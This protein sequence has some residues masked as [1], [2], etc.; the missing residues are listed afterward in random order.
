[1]VNDYHKLC[2]V[3]QIS[4]TFPVECMKTGNEKKWID[5]LPL[6]F[7]CYRDFPNYCLNLKRKRKSKVIDCFA[8]SCAVVAS[9]F[10]CLSAF[11]Y[12]FPFH[13]SNPM[14]YVKWYTSIFDLFGAF[15]SR[16]SVRSVSSFVHICL[17][18]RETQ[19]QSE[20][21]STLCAVRHLLFGIIC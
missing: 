11:F 3:P 15:F 16:F 19:Q 18:I 20:I 1:M 5:E 7:V 14:L 12:S 10:L 21:H 17:E 6:Y 2:I 8:V 9:V 4:H 13:S